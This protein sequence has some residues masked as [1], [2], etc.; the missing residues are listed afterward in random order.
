VLAA[1]LL[2]HERVPASVALIDR[3]PLV[4]RGVAYGTQFA[5]HLLNVRAKDMSA[6]PD[7]PDHFLEWC[8]RN[9]D[10]R[11]DA[12]GFLP[13]RLYG[14][15][16][17]SILEEQIRSHPD[18]LGFVREEAVALS[19]VRDTWEILL[20]HGQRLQT[21]KVVLALGNFPP[22]DP[23]LPGKAENSTRYI[24]NP[25]SLTDITNAAKNQGVLL[26]GSGL[27]AVDVAMDLRARRFA[28]AIHLLSRRG[29]LP[30]A[31]L[32]VS[33]LP[34]CWDSTW[35]NTARG[36]LRLLRD[37]SRLAH[38]KGSDW[39]AVI[40]SL[41]PISQQ[42]WC[43]LPQREKRRFLRHLRPYW[44]VHRHRIAPR[45]AEW[46]SS[47]FRTG[48]IQIHAGRITDYREDPSGVLV[49]YR[50][51]IDGS[52]VQLQLGLV[53][54]CTGPEANPLRISS[55]LLTNLIATGTARPD[56]LYLGL[57]VAEDGALIGAN[58]IASDFLYAAGPARKGQSWESNAVPEIRVQVQKLASLL[59][60]QSPLSVSRGAA[61]RPRSR[62]VKAGSVLIQR[63]TPI[64]LKNSW[65]GIR[66]SGRISKTLLRI[67][68]NSCFIAV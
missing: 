36:L 46:M 2:R 18:R 65:V 24:S 34:P 14:R 28:G 38:G 45:I 35:P 22:S 62:I 40:D 3:K 13:R 61:L 27:T 52:M 55:P 15:Y 16:I 41:R 49:Q 59:A 48:G 17:S 67:S 21:E 42:I 32:T 37:H 31:H 29:L 12:C 9:Y 8:R 58:G 66:K 56:F 7:S 6:Y 26:I 50:R 43:S 20:K 23:F 39:R 19:R 60:S 54:N 25:W 51:R 1:Q 30:Q 11:V 44:E 53:I 68:L 10:P 47:E 63:S 57:D 64:R 4:G 5:G 33:P